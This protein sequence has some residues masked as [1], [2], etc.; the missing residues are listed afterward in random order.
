MFLADDVIS[1]SG[2]IIGTKRQRITLALVAALS[3]YAK[4]RK[5]PN[6]FQCWYMR[7]EGGVP[8]GANMNRT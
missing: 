1:A 5:S 6:R 2:V 8:V 3:N 7:S 4:N